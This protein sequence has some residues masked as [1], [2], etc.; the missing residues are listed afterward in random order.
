MKTNST[1]HA[2]KI[3]APRKKTIAI[4]SGR[5]N[6]ST[7]A[8]LLRSLAGPMLI[9]ESPNIPHALSI[10]VNREVIFCKADG[11]RKYK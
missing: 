11:N 3:R 8:F 9:A 6:Y 10:D 4:S 2:G 5:I 1:K 7:S